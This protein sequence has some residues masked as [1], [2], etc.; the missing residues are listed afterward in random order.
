[1]PFDPV[2]LSAGLFIRL[3]ALPFGGVQGANFFGLAAATGLEQ[4]GPYLW[5]I[6]FTS[7]ALFSAIFLTT[8]KERDDASWLF[9]AAMSVAAVS[10]GF[11]IITGRATSAF[12]VFAGPRYN[13]IP[14]ALIGLCFLSLATR[15][16]PV[17][18]RMPRLLLGLML[19]VGATHYLRPFEDY[20]QGPSW[21]MEVAAWRANPDH[22]LAV[23]PGP[24]AADLSNRAIRCSD[25]SQ[26]KASWS[27][28]RYCQEGWLTSF[29][30]WPG[31]PT[32]DP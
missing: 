23:W 2:N 4:G 10:L 3:L 18:R 21:S 5:L 22:Q 24:Y 16:H 7:V 13:Y 29:S 25:A 12:F 8:L 17:E 11:G 20:A 27:A 26:V 30:T 31:Q 32:P 6:A 9:A 14:L 19:F 1:V 28:P 15:S